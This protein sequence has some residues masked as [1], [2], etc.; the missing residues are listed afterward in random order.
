MEG[1]DL[2]G[3]KSLVEQNAA[4]FSAA[5]PAACQAWY[6]QGRSEF[7]LNNVTRAAEILV[8]AGKKCAEH[9]KDRG[10]RALYIAGKSL[11]RK[12]EWAR[13]AAAFEAIPRLYPEH[14]MAD[15]GYALGGIGRQES[16]DLSAAMALWEAGANAYPKGDLAPETFWRLAWNSYRQG[17]TADALRWVDRLIAETDP[18]LD[19]VHQLGARYWQ[20]RWRVYPDWSAPTVRNPDEREVLIGIEQ[21]SALVEENPTRFYSLLAAGRLYELAP[22]KV[23]ELKRPAPV[24]DAR[25]WTVSGRYYEDPAARR[26]LALARLG[27]VSEAMAELESMDEEQLLPSEVALM[28]E[29][30]ER[31]DELLAHD[32]LHHYLLEHPAETLGGDRDRILRQAYPNMYWDLVQ[33]AAQG[34]GYDPRIFHALVREESSFNKDIVSH[35]GA[36]GLSQLMPATART[37]AGWMGMSVSSQGMFDP[38]TNLRIGSR[39]LDYL[40]QY[41]KGNM[42]LAVG[43]YNA[44]EG[45]VGNWLKERRERPT[46][47]FIEAVPLRET[48][49][50]IKRVL[51]TY[52][53][54]SVLYGDGP[55]YPDWSKTNHRAGMTGN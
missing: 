41:F 2:S 34:F 6:A 4:R 19:P 5:S 28:N 44:G 12:K 36:R 39:Y 48:R 17:R 33:K 21:W 25:T 31:K 9:D 27:L 29:I 51:G 14:T 45:N 40:R 46:D 32:R 8:P 50:Y 15:D 1:N 11:E 35:A 42:Y 55:L 26:G 49:H 37:V 43:A 20:A 38:F 47:E 22:D 54:Y 16:G 10:A 7:K 53:L 13:A 18:R 24:G 52:Q 30:L 3:A 23:R